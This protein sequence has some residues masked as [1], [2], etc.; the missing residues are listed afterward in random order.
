M[1]LNRLS[2]L[3][4]LLSLCLVAPALAHPE[5]A[6][7]KVTI[8]GPGIE[9]ALEITDAEALNAFGL[10][11]FMVFGRSGPLMPQ[12]GETYYEIVRY[13]KN[14]DGSLWEF[15]RL[16]YYTNPNSQRGYILYVEGV[17]QSRAGNW[18]STT[19][20][21]ES[22]MKRIIAS[23]PQAGAAS[24][25]IAVESV[26]PIPVAGAPMPAPDAAG[27][28]STSGVGPPMASSQIPLARSAWMFGVAAIAA[29]AGGWFVLRP[30]GA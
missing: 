12:V 14:D 19:A 5:G 4:L 24:P 30:R 21:G 29:L 11:T 18:Y 17:M 10:E 9:G 15:D 2:L 23:L 7:F 16:R 28:P 27:N 1:R 8:A 6:L 26:A 22:A 25:Q 20:E 3:S 13:F